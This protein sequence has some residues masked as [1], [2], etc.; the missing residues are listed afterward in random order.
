MLLMPLGELVLY[1]SGVLIPQLRA[2]MRPDVGFMSTKACGHKP[3][4]D[5]VVAYDNGCFAGTWTPGPW[6]AWLDKQPRGLFGVVPDVYCDARATR[7]RFDQYAHIVAGKQP[8]AYVAQNGS[9]LVPPPWS[10]FDVLFI[11]GSNAFKLSEEAWSLVREAKR[12]GKWVHQGRVNSFR[13]LKACAV[14]GVDSADGTLLRL[15]QSRKYKGNN[16]KWP[17]LCA[18][19]DTL[20][21]Q[22]RMFG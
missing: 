7:E 17:M 11:G 4:P 14:S 12:R 3:S 16:P 6:Q 9:A 10:Q 19:L 18:W 8:V 5:M 1:L 2:A 20:K 22:H 21:Q 15:G 13:R